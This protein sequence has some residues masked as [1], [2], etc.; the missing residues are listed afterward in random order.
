[1]TAPFT[2]NV[3]VSFNADAIKR[4]FSGGA[5]SGNIFEA[6]E[7]SEDVFVLSTKGNNSFLG[8]RHEVSNGMI[9]LE[10]IDAD[11]FEVVVGIISIIPE[12]L[13]SG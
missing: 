7:S 8:L 11:G 2:P 6:L 9:T 12:L 13:I 10:L 1:M 4:V 5:H 3:L